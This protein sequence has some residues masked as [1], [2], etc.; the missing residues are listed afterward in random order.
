V[1]LKR[2]IS[3]VIPKRNAATLGH[4]QKTASRNTRWFWNFLQSIRHRPQSKWRLR[5]K[6]ERSESA[7]SRW[8]FCFWRSCLDFLGTPYPRTFLLAGKL[9][10]ASETAIGDR[11]MADYPYG[12][13]CRCAC[14]RFFKLG[15]YHPQ[16]RTLPSCCMV[17]DVPARLRHG[18]MREMNMSIFKLIPRL[19]ATLRA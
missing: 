3:K 9:N 13:V 10:S 5:A 11:Q 7:Y 2:S 18:R 4:S 1:L 17:S 14:F 16:I 8:S 12:S 19:V 15:H 6:A